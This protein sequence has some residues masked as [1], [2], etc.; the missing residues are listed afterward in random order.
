MA[1]RSSKRSREKRCDPPQNGDLR[2]DLSEDD[3][4]EELRL[5]PA[6]WPR[7]S[8]S[9]K[10][11]TNLEIFKESLLRQVP[12]T[13][14]G[15][16]AKVSQREVLNALFGRKPMNGTPQEMLAL[17]ELLEELHPSPNPTLETLLDLEVP[18][19]E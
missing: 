11:R 10:T 13:S 18:S 19:L 14:D 4:L 3:E 16:K 7:R 15:K 12:L 8:R 6:Y 1:G 9:K 17:I 2:D 5:R